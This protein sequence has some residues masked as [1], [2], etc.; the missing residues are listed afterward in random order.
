[1]PSLTEALYVMVDSERRWAEHRAGLSSFE[2]RHSERAR[3]RIRS[4]PFFV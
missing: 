4:G 1:V 2:R 3:V